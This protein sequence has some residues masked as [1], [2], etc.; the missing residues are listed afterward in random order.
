MARIQN[1]EKP[2]LYAHVLGILFL[3]YAPLQ[4]DFSGS[5]IFMANLPFSALMKRVNVIST[6][7]KRVN[8]IIKF[9]TPEED[10]QAWFGAD[11]HCATIS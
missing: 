2:P 1:Q 4:T 10:T 11:S 6:L 7:M 5:V 3:L 8:I 9:Q